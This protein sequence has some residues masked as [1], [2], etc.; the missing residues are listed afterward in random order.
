MEDASHCAKFNAKSCNAFQNNMITQ[1]I[2]NDLTTLL[3]IYKYMLNCLTT[4]YTS[5]VL[6]ID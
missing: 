1:E 2:C 5:H 6:I 4:G 3:I